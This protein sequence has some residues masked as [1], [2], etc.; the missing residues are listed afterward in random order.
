M[1][2][3]YWIARDPPIYLQEEVPYSLVSYEY[4][5][6]LRPRNKFLPILFV[7]FAFF[8]YWLSLQGALVQSSLELMSAFVT[9]RFKLALF[10]Q[11]LFLTTNL[12]FFIEWLAFRKVVTAIKYLSPANWNLEFEW[13]IWIDDLMNRKSIVLISYWWTIW[14]FLILHSDSYYVLEG[15][16][17]L[18]ITS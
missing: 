4:K 15:R 7:N 17:A 5:S 16:I 6:F 11:I 3:I 10:S 9:L 14:Y 18:V 13:L 2:I 1:Q 8:V 12:I